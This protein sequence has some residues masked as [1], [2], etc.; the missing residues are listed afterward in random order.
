ML[1]EATVR[2]AQT[3]DTSAKVFILLILYLALNTIQRIKI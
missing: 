3:S 1:Q 2:V